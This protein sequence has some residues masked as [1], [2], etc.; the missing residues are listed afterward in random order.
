[1]ANGMAAI[2]QINLWWKMSDAC[3]VLNVGHAEGP[4]RVCN[5]HGNEHT[6]EF[7]NVVPFN[8]H[9]FFDPFER[10]CSV[11]VLKHLKKCRCR[12]FCVGNMSLHCLLWDLK[13]NFFKKKKTRTK[14]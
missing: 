5:I 8:F 12:Y 1:M 7:E 2:R 6:T 13:T 10:V 3:L 11:S 14:N 4:V 9:P